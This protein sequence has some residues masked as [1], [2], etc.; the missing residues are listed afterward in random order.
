MH[1]LM[2]L[3]ALAV[4]LGFAAYLATGTWRFG[5]EVAGVFLAWVLI[6]YLGVVAADP[7]SITPGAPKA[8]ESQQEITTMLLTN[9]NEH[10]V[11]IRAQC[12]SRP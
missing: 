1:I 7:S 10:L 12:V 6:G 8:P 2:S 5:I 4:L 11:Q 9:I 3:T